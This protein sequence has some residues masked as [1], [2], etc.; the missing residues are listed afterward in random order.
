M[1]EEQACTD[2][3]VEFCL[4]YEGQ[5]LRGGGPFCP[6]ECKAFMWCRRNERYIAH[7]VRPKL[8]ATWA[9]PLRV[10]DTVKAVVHSL[11]N[12][13]HALRSGDIVWHL[14]VLDK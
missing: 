6:V 8:Q 1:R 2:E 14:Y 12:T 10:P 9:R 13:G 5:L 3:L 11:R 7:V 4:E